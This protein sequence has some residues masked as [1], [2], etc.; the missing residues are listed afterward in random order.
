MK[1][2]YN[3]VA[4]S[5]FKSEWYE[6]GIFFALKKH[7]LFIK[8]MQSHIKTTCSNMKCS[9]PCFT[10][11]AKTL[12]IQVTPKFVLWQTVMLHNVAFH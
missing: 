11:P 6:L 7:Q 1:F 10:H 3:C 5:P 8:K 12:Y 2:F 9:P 4:M